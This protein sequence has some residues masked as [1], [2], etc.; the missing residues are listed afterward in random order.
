MTILWTSFPSTCAQPAYIPV[1]ESGNVSP[2]SSSER[3]AL[4]LYRRVNEKRLKRSRH[5]HTQLTSEYP[6]PCYLVE[7]LSPPFLST[8]K[9]WWSYSLVSM[10]LST[11]LWWMHVYVSYW[12]SVSFWRRRL[13]RTERKKIGNFWLSCWDVEIQSFLSVFFS[14]V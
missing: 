10:I 7:T 9:V 11:L 1:S 4:L 5:T 3:F 8:S 14:K 2:S 13:E 6:I 12:I